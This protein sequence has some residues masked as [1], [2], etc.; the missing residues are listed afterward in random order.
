MVLFRPGFPFF[1]AVS[2]MLLLAL[3]LKSSITMKNYFL[4]FKTKILQVFHIIFYL[5]FVVIVIL[6]NQILL[7]VISLIIPLFDSFDAVGACGRLAC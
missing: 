4:L 3:I 2:F 5:T 7:V 1:F 6:S